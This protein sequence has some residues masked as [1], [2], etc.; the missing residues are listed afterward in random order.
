MRKPL[1]DFGLGQ[2]QADM[3]AV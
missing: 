1:I 3:A 2:P